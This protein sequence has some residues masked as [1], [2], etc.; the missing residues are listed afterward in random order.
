MGGVALQT[1]FSALLLK[2]NLPSSR[3][4]GNA[5]SIIHS[6]LQIYHTS[7][8]KSLFLYTGF[9]TFLEGYF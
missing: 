8:N 4:A 1:D 9:L 7:R 3:C 6:A 2:K 5:F